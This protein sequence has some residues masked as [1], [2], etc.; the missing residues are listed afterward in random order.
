MAGGAHDAVDPGWVPTKMGGPSAT[1]DLRLGHVTQVWLA[2]SEDSEAR[3]R[4]GYWFHRRRQDPHPAVLDTR[5]Q[6]EL[7]SALA[8]YTGTELD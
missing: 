5:C 4:G 1:D 2:T 6:E 7:V 8:S 3:T